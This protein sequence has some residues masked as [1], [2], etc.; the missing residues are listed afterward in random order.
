MR[1]TKWTAVPPYAVI[2]AATTN[3]WRALAG[4]LVE[5]YAI[6]NLQSAPLLIDSRRPLFTAPPSAKIYLPEVLSS[7]LTFRQAKSLLE[8]IVLQQFASPAG[9]RQGV[10]GVGSKARPTTAAVRIK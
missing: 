6:C 10:K 1:A 3:L 7:A 4:I 5:F 8:A 9:A 2:R